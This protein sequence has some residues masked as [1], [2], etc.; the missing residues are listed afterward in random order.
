MTV[1]F[2]GKFPRRQAFFDHNCHFHHRS[3]SANFERFV[4]GGLSVFVWIFRGISPEQNLR[5]LIAA[6]IVIKALNIQLCTQYPVSIL[7]FCTDGNHYR[8]CRRTLYTVLTVNDM[9]SSGTLF[10]SI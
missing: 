1:S 8:H 10:F 9:Q 4:F 3:S 5:D 7:L 6:I 2:P